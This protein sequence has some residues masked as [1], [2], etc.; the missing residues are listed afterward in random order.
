MAE[1]LRV[2]YAGR[3]ATEPSMQ[4]TR[5]GKAVTNFSVAYNN[6][7]GD[8]DEVTWLRCTVWGDRAE[9]V[10]EMCQKGT[11]VFL[12]GRLNPDERGNPRIWF[13]KETDEPRTSFEVT[14]YNIAFLGELRPSGEQ[15]Y[16]DLDAPLDTD[17]SPPGTGGA[18]MFD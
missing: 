14:V 18:S 5:N 1:I 17:D 13:D 11:Y 15:P 2:E 4:Y 6:K 8:K 7:W 10:N 3:L 12:E 16:A 9:K